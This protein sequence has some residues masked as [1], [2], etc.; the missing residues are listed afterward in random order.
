VNTRCRQPGRAARDIAV[1]PLVPRSA[2]RPLAPSVQREIASRFGHDFGSVR[3]HAGADAAKSATM[4]GA[5]AYTVGNDIVFGAGEYRESGNA[6]LAHELAHVVQQDGVAAGAAARV[7]D[8]HDRSERTADAAVGDALAGRVPATEI[9]R[10]LRAAAP[11]EPV[12]QRS[13]KSWGGE[14]FTDRFE[15]THRSGRNGVGIT[16]RFEPNENVDARK[17]MML[18]IINTRAGGQ[19]Q[20]NIAQEHERAPTQEE[21]ATLRE[22]T[23]A[24]GE[25]G[26]GTRIDQFAAGSNP[27]YATSEK[28]HK[29]LGSAPVDTASGQEGWRYTDDQ[30]FEQRR[31]ATLL[32]EPAQALSAGASQMFETAAL[33]VAGTQA[34][35][36]YGSVKWGW[37]QNPV[38]MTKFE[39]TLAAND[40]PSRTFTAAARR[41][42]KS[43]TSLGEETTNLPLGKRAFVVESQAS[44]VT[45][46]DDPKRTEIARLA[47][48]TR[49]Q[50]RT[51]SKGRSFNQGADVPWWRV[52]VISGPDAG[53][54]G[55]MRSNTISG[56]Q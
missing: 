37:V 30:G 7:S 11:A 50:I 26:A 55:W 47:I 4:L 1:S 28:T 21:Q 22:R 18:Q 48:G 25:P 51:R 54:A 8:P 16:L 35:T 33:A 20:F 39:P 2:G 53:A 46:P 32:D 40:V 5:R 29:S 17:I 12:V 24:E 6:L 43:K 31:P 10:L 9:H 23:I 42:N 36:Y 15:E 3:V 41:W 45:R 52:T 27:L 34:Y 56:I 14:F 13:V 38:G 44:L 49:V 19:P